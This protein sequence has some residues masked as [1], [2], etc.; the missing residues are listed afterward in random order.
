M[1][2]NSRQMESQKCVSTWPLNRFSHRKIAHAVCL[3]SSFLFLLFI[4]IP[5]SL[6]F[7]CSPLW[8]PFLLSLKGD[9]KDAKREMDH[10]PA[11]IPP[12]HLSPRL[13]ASPFQRKRLYTKN[14]PPFC[15][16]LTNGSCLSLCFSHSHPYT[17]RALAAS[18]STAKY[19]TGPP[20]THPLPTRVSSGLCGINEL[21]HTVLS[22]SIAL[23]PGP[24]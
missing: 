10:P 2:Q 18:K 21:I 13:K 22:G 19:H 17:L 14:H 20:P 9:S 6:R 11:H 5:R 1:C 24:M 15:V 8:N 12:S 4:R 16:F 7:S 23:Q 3:S